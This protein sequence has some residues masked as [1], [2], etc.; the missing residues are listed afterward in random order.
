MR[1]KTVA[2]LALAVLT[3]VGTSETGRAQA[4][5]SCH[6]SGTTTQPYYAD[7]YVV[8]VGSVIVTPQ[9]NGMCFLDDCPDPHHCEIKFAAS[10]SV[11]YNTS[12][13]PKSGVHI[14]D[15]AYPTYDW[16]MLPGEGSGSGVNFYSIGSV[17]AVPCGH[18]YSGRIYVDYG[19]G[20]YIEVGGGDLICG[21]CGT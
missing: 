12:E 7:N 3:M 2:A 8:V 20:A 19:G 21:G 6:A 9:E 18:T 17:I 10:W 1:M 13:V 4:G 16:Q 5:C 15:N 11:S 14:Y